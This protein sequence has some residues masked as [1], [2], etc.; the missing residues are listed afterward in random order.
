MTEQKTCEWNVLKSCKKYISKSNTLTTT[1]SESSSTCTRTS[2]T[3]RSTTPWKASGTVVTIVG[4]PTRAAHQTVAVATMIS[5][6]IRA[7]ASW[8]CWRPEKIHNFE[9]LIWQ[10]CMPTT[11]MEGVEQIAIRTRNSWFEFIKQA[12]RNDIF[13][14]SHRR[15][16]GLELHLDWICNQQPERL[17]HN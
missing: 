14:T 16:N 8:G 5:M 11:K 15:T 10:N 12:L 2:G 4:T 9:E 1:I 7:A 13:D 17:K 6:A 3:P